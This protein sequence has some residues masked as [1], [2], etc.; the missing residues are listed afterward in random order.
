METAFIDIFAHFG[1]RA[2]SYTFA[3]VIGGLMVVVIHRA[4]APV[5]LSTIDEVRDAT[6]LYRKLRSKELS[7]M[8]D[9]D[10]DLIGRLVQSFS[11]L[12]GAVFLGIVMIVSDLA[13][14]V[15]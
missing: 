15:G 7:E 10:K 4:F 2:L 1:H 13:T 6:R 12:A 3:L 11:I 14:P 8:T 5:L 9:S